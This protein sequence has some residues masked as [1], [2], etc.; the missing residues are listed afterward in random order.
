LKITFVGGGNMA[1]ALI[2]GL[3]ADLNASFTIRVIEP[4]EA[5]RHSLTERWGMLEVYEAPVPAAFDSADVVVLAVKPQQ[6]REVAHAIS[7]LLGGQLVISVAAGIRSHDLS[8]WLG[9]HRRIV[10]T[11]PNTPAL[12]GRGVTGL[13]LLE[14]ARTEDRG[15]AECILGAVGEIVWVEDEHLLDAVTAV[16][17]SGPAYVFRV[18]EAMEAAG[19]ALGLDAEQARRLTIATFVGAAELA[20]RSGESPSLLRARVTSKGGTTAAALAV[21]EARD[22]SGLFSE[23]LAAAARRGEEM[24]REFGAS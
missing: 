16:S 20:S 17:G 4:L 6:M 15:I 22:L 2:G 8:R 14:P 13:A 7:S 3:L 9:G 19:V 1:S 10:R 18:M 11:M 23:A 12:I 24:G 5:Q 21:M